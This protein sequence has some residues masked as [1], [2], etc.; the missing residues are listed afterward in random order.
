M[1][2]RCTFRR[3]Q[4][5]KSSKT[6]VNIITYNVNRFYRG[7]GE[8]VPSSQQGCTRFPEI[9]CLFFLFRRLFVHLLCVFYVTF[10]NKVTLNLLSFRILVLFASFLQKFSLPARAGEKVFKKRCKKNEA[11]DTQILTI[12]DM[13]KRCVKVTQKVCIVVFGGYNIAGI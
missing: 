12:V 10:Q 13:R 7:G 4:K 5:S 8:G 1:N 11:I 2:V 6:M 9:F 3:N